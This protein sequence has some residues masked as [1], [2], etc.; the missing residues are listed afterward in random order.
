MVSINT[1]EN[2]M[3]DLGMFDFHNGDSM[4]A[5]WEGQ[6]TASHSSHGKLG[7]SQS[8][9]LWDRIRLDRLRAEDIESSTTEG[10][11]NNTLCIQAQPVKS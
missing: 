7:E 2:N 5:E 10:S 11:K 4:I 6:R 3:P 1:I 8:Q 9:Y